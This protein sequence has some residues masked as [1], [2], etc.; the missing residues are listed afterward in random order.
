MSVS[1][2]SI[3]TDRFYE[4]VERQE[5]HIDLLDTL[6]SELVGEAS[7]LRMTFHC[8][9]APLT[10]ETTNRLRRICNVLAVSANSMALSE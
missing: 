4:L 5:Q 3:S 8:L 7:H 6:V 9:G 10:P 2:L 1:E